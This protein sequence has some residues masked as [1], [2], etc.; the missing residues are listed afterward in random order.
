MR[1]KYSFWPVIIS[2]RNNQKWRPLQLLKDIFLIQKYNKSKTWILLSSFLVHLS[3]PLP[4]S[5]SSENSNRLQQ[6]QKAFSDVDSFVKQIR[7]SSSD[8]DIA[9]IW[10]GIP[11]KKQPDVIK[12]IFAKEEFET[13]EDNKT[14]KKVVEAIKKKESIDSKIQNILADNLRFFKEPKHASIREEIYSLFK[15]IASHITV[16]T[17]RKLAELIR[18]GIPTKEKKRI[19]EILRERKSKD[20]LTIQYLGEGLNDFSPEVREAAIEALGEILGDEGT[21]LKLYYDSIYPSFVYPV[22]NWFSVDKSLPNVRFYIMSKLQDK[23]LYDPNP[24]VR[25]AAIEAMDKINSFYARSIDTFIEVISSDSNSKVK[26]KA[27]SALGRAGFPKKLFHRFPFADKMPGRQ[28]TIKNLTDSLYHKNPRIRKE[29]R[30]AFRAMM[31]LDGKEENKNPN[32][33]ALKEYYKIQSLKAEELERRIEEYEA[34]NIQLTYDNFNNK[35]PPPFESWFE[36]EVFL[37][38]H[39]KGYIVLPQPVY[40]ASEI[41]QEYRIDMVIVSSDK[42]SRLAVECNGPPH[43]NRQ[44]EDENRKKE[45]ERAGWTVWE[46]SHSKEKTSSL[47]EPYLYSYYSKEWKDRKVDEESLDELWETLDK[48]KIEPIRKNVN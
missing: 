36:V 37:R 5:A 30:R 16:K 3:F 35:V 27:I 6:C 10:K 11:V 21:L 18:G 12:K 41:G 14:R 39:K 33:K 45:L 2:I 26:D 38:I 47:P 20:A 9:E 29:A 34:T 1:Y 23:M 24:S 25:E 7:E 28:E 8:S 46:I 31:S 44:V 4:T 42:N 22:V 48:M 17:A 15:K 19:I 32:L 13:A 43:I 40:S